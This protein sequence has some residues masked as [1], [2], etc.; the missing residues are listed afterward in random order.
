MTIQQHQDPIRTTLRPKAKDRSRS[1]VIALPEPDLSM[2]QDEEWCLVRLE[3]EWRE[4]RFHDYADV[5]RVKGLYEHLFSKTLRC[6]SPATIRAM[7]RKQLAKSGSSPKDLRVLDLGAGNGMVGEELANLGVETIVGVDIVEEAAQA[8]QRDRPGVYKDYFV[9]DITQLTPEQRSTLEEYRFNALTCVA[10]LGFGDIPPEA[11]AEAYNL[12]RNGGWIAFNIKE[13]FLDDEIGAFA[14]LIRTMIDR[15][16]LV[17]EAKERYV[18]RL[19]T[20]RE[21]LH[22]YALVGVKK[23]DIDA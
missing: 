8:A 20:N 18:H 11:F 1:F 3:S 5:Y 16:D 13:T 10:A 17:V 12:V 14:R 4:V 2:P 19:G 23:A 6:D 22:Y 15:G 9:S 21:P 7:L